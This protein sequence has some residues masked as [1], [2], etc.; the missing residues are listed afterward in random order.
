MDGIELIAAERQRQVEQE[1]WTPAHDDEHAHGEMAMAAVCYAACY[2]I[3]AE[4]PTLIYGDENCGCREADC[5]HRS[6]FPHTELAW[7]DPWPWDD[8][9]DKRRKHRNLRRLVIAGAL[10]AAEIDRLQRAEDNARQQRI[11]NGQE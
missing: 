7:R 6:I 8:E 1:G 11:I 2:P 5:P 3:Q 9:W 4:V 10:I